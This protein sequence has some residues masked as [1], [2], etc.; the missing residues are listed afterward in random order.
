[1]EEDSLTAEI[2]KHVK[3]RPT[4]TGDINTGSDN[5]NKQTLAS[6][7]RIR[8]GDI[9]AS[10]VFGTLAPTSLEV[11]DRNEIDML[12]RPHAPRSRYR[13]SSHDDR[14]GA[15]SA[16]GRP[17]QDI[18][19]ISNDISGVN[20]GS[21]DTSIGLQDQANNRSILGP[22]N[23]RRGSKDTDTMRTYEL[24]SKPNDTMSSRGNK[25]KFRK[26]KEQNI[27]ELLDTLQYFG[28]TNR[29]RALAATETADTIHYVNINDQGKKKDDI[30]HSTS[31]IVFQRRQIVDNFNGKQVAVAN[32]SFTIPE[33]PK[34]S[35]L[36]INI[37]S[38]WGKL[39]HSVFTNT[40]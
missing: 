35:L 13:R 14:D 15:M 22:S 21:S 9:A 16:K 23:D 20:I 7:Q 5:A 29:G 24:S 27:S 6:K 11:H 31:N 4:T 17:N 39:F 33:L 2:N 32:T 38:T 30:N 26:T 40:S 19:R 28:R 37:L 10:R 25:R 36:V 12:V 1:M 34:G 18:A 3:L 8:I